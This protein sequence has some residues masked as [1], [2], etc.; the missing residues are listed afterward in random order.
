MPQIRAEAQERSAQQPDQLPS[1][2]VTAPDV[3]PLRRMARQKP[4]PNRSA[5]TRNVAPPE[6][7]REAPIVGSSGV[8]PASSDDATDL[9]PTAASSIRFTGAEVNAVP[10]TRPGEALEIV[11]GLIVTQHSAEGK[12]NQYFLRGFN[13]DHGTDLA[14]TVH[15]MPVNVPTH[16]HGQGYADINFLIPEL[17]QSVKGPY[18]AD[19]GDF[20][21]AGA[22]GI[23]YVNRLPQNIAEVSFGSFGYRRGIAAGSTSFGRHVARG[24]RR[25]E[26][27]RPTGCAGRRAQAQWHAAL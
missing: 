1:V 16:G 7:Q 5:R 25:N 12:A 18:F 24:Y 4:L 27:R 22:V 3:K 11:P 6:Q 26:V 20:G 8:T 14:I 23:D 21:S 19:V 10:F 13:L 9:R 17:I 15:G 2:T